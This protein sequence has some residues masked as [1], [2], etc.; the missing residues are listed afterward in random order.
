MRLEGKVALVSGASRNIGRS[1]AL[2]FAREGATVTLGSRTREADLRAVA[3]ECARAGAEVLPVLGDVGTSAGATA[4]VDRTLERFGR[5]DVIVSLAAVRPHTP[6]LELTYDEW[7]EVLAVNLD[8][9]FHLCKAAVPGMVERGAGSIIALGGLVALTGV[10]D[11]AASS[12]SKTGLLGLIRS[13]AVELG[14]HGIRANMVVPGN[15][16]TAR[17][18]PEWY[19][20]LPD[21]PSSGA[22]LSRIPL[23]RLGRPDEIAAACVFLASDDSSYV[24]GSQLVCNGGSFIT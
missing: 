9:T 22:H 23:R 13:L 12:A 24:T 10:P 3:D 18:N 14:P 1:V 7:R 16:D 20:T 5:V 21:Q 11:A 6:F 19:R 2:A 8:A 15:V 4:L 17:A